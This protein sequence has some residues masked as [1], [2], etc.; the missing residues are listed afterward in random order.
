MLFPLLFLELTTV[1]I[2]FSISLL[3]L[4]ANSSYDIL[5]GTAFSSSLNKI[6]FFLWLFKNFCKILS[7][8]SP[9]LS[10]VYIITYSV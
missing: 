4:S 9:P 8:I 6:V 7:D 5:P 1:K 2:L 10:Y 3:M